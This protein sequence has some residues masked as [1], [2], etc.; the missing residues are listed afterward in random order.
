MGGGVMRGMKVFAGLAMLGMMLGQAWAWPTEVKPVLSEADEARY[1]KL[2]A[3][4]RDGK[5]PLLALT[6]GLEDKSLLADVE[7]VYMEYGKPTYGE[8]KTWLNTNGDYPQA[9]ALYSEAKRERPM[10][11]RTCK[12]IKVKQ[13]DGTLRSKKS[14]QTTGTAAP[15]PD[16]PRALI[17]REQRARAAEAAREAQYDGLASAV[18]A[19]RRQILGEVWNLRKRGLLSKAAEV[20][21]APGAKEAVGVVRWQEEVVRTASLLFNQREFGK[22]LAVALPATRVSGPVR[23]DARWL[24]GFS[25][26]LFPNMDIPLWEFSICECVSS[27]DVCKEPENKGG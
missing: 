17:L 8:L 27:R 24:A 20:L 16:M 13:K 7:A 2:F 26:R 5:K 18:A 21:N 6:E 9:V 12:T 1:E 22:T 23:D 14:C 11:K 4:A 25:K 15:L 19:Q 10:P 3:D